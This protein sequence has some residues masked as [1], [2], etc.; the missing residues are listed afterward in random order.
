MLWGPYLFQ[1]LC[2]ALATSMMSAATA[3]T[4]TAVG[5]GTAKGYGQELCGQTYM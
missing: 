4:D 1:G 2:S 3:V 5:K